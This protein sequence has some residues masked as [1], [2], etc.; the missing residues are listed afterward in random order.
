MAPWTA[1]PG[2]RRARVGRETFPLSVF[3]K[4]TLRRIPAP[5]RL[6]DT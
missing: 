1:A 4:E 6:R 3:E 5:L 2:S